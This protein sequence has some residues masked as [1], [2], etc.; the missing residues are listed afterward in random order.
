MLEIESKQSQIHREVN[1]ANDKYDLKF[2]IKEDMLCESVV[3]KL[4]KDLS[5]AQRVTVEKMEAQ[6]VIFE[7]EK[8]LAGLT[9]SSVRCKY[10]MILWQCA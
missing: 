4:R 8:A 1:E 10:E 6:R 3:M 7:A 5:D 2:E 9:A